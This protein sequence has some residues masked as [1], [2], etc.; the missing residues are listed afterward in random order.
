MRLW[1]YRLIPYLPKSQLIAQWRELNSIY[2]KEDDHI[3]INYIYEYN[4]KDLGIYSNIVIQEMLSRGIKIKNWKN[5]EEYFKDETFDVCELYDY[6]PFENHQDNRY[7]LQCFM[8]LSEKY[9]RGQK[10]FDE[11]T[12]NKLYHF[13]NK[14][15]NGIL[16]SINEKL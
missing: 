3:L 15:L 9:F 4:K 12:Y 10:D 5:Y 7:L 8:N 13:V 6:E 11:Q 16:D 2:K 1:D 14:E